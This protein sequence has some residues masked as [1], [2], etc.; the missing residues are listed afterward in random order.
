MKKAS[1]KRRASNRM[2]DTLESSDSVSSAAQG[3]VMIFVGGNIPPLPWPEARN[4]PH[5]MED[6]FPFLLNVRSERCRVYRRPNSRGALP[7]IRS[8][9]WFASC[10]FKSLG[11]L[12]LNPCG[13]A[14]RVEDASYQPDQLEL[15]VVEQV[16]A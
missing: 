7:G 15:L 10:R 4:H 13:L 2:P 6:H 11:Q 8:T 16:G 3:K 1:R 9:V 14:S 5:S 12:L